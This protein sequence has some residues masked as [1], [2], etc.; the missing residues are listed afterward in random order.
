M[1]LIVRGT[2]KLAWNRP[3]LALLLEELH[4]DDLFF[5]LVGPPRRL[6]MNRYAQTLAVAVALRHSWRRD[7]LFDIARRLG[8][9]L[10]ERDLRRVA[11]NSPHKTQGPAKQECGEKSVQRR[12]SRVS[13]RR[14]H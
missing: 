4:V 7:D 5:E 2:E 3:L 14:K 10:C 12:S 13:L 8:I 11:K 9:R 1:R 6:P